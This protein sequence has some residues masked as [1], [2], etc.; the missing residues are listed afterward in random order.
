MT[1]HEFGVQIRNQVDRANRAVNEIRDVKAQ[2][3][4]RLAATD[5]EGSESL[6]QCEVEAVCGGVGELV[7]VIEVLRGLGGAGAY[8]ECDAGYRQGRQ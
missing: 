6:D 5:D 1:Q 8:A 7:E 4:E 3:E 2:L